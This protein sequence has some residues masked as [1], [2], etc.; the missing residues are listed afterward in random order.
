MIAIVM[1]VAVVMSFTL[2]VLVE[3]DAYYDHCYNEV[4]LPQCKRQY[5]EKFGNAN[6][7]PACDEF[8]KNH[9][10]GDTD[11]IDPKVFQ[12]YTDRF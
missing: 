8:C 2:A 11:D 7:P 6:C 10:L 5:S 12:K 1:L 9:E 4:C 3:A